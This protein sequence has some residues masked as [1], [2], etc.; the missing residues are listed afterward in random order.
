MTA[1]PFLPDRLVVCLPPEVQVEPTL[2][3]ASR[4]AAALTGCALELVATPGHTQ[5][6]ERRRTIEA[7]IG[8]RPDAI[9]LVPRPEHV[10]GFAVTRA[11]E[12]G[13]VV[14]SSQRRIRRGARSGATL[15]APGDLSH[16]VI[17]AF[18][19]PERDDP[20][21]LSTAVELA[22]R[23]GA[24]RV[25]A[26]RVAFDESVLCCS[27][28]EARER[29]REEERLQLQLARLPDHHGLQVQAS[30]VFAPPTARTFARI[31]AEHDAALVVSGELTDLDRPILTLPRRGTGRMASPS[32]AAWRLLTSGAAAR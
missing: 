9:H 2:A 5:P 31:A 30:M 11:G 27:E 25:V 21:V 10:L 17:V 14:T 1:A 15:V 20:P 12:A 18:A 13:L 16:R 3:R 4:F 26:C 8:R 7:V 29:A 22:R 19:E 32:E 6:R 28:C 24:S 23:F